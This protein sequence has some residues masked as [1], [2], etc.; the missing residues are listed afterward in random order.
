MSDEG[1]QSLKTLRVS[2]KVCLVARPESPTSSFQTGLDESFPLVSQPG[3]G[4]GE[5]SSEPPHGNSNE[6]GKG[7]LWNV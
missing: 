2:P 5:V 4:L 3:D 1:L 6:C 7:T